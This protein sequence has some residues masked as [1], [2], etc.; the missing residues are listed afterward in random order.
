[1]VEWLDVTNDLDEVSI[2]ELE[3]RRLTLRKRVNGWNEEKLKMKF[4]AFII[5]L[6][7]YDTDDLEGVFNA[8]LK[9]AV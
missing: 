7:N 8:K 1:M 5:D 4:I 2:T 6:V 9:G 3:K